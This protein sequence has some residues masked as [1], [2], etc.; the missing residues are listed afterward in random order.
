MAAGGPVSQDGDADGADAHVVLPPLTV[1][2]PKMRSPHTP[3]PK[4]KI[5]L[6]SADEWEEFTY[7]WV[8]ALEEGYVGIELGGGTGD[9]G[10]D[11]AAFLTQSKFNGDWHSYQCKHYSAPLPLATAMGEILKVFIAAWE[12]HYALPSRYVFVAPNISRGLQ[13][14]L[15]TPVELKKAFLKD[16]TKPT[17]KAF[18]ALESA[19]RQ[20]VEQLAEANDFSLFEA[21]NLDDI[22]DLHRTTRHYAT[23]FDEPFST[24]PEV[25]F[26]PEEHASHESR[27]IQQLLDVYAEHF[28]AGT[29]ND[30]TAHDKAGPHLKRQREAFYSAEA[31]RMFAR[32]HVP[33]GH[34]EA[35]QDDLYDSVV[36]VADRDFPNGW[37]RVQAVLEA[38]T[39]VQVTETHLIRVVRTRDR[40]GVCHQLANDDRLTWCTGETT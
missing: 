9:R 16:L 33:E 18:T 30:V 37:A 11:V 22:L 1:L 23:R 7:E 39:Q 38:S 34:F 10:V 36:E 3:T 8:R 27:Y 15:A 40:K 5:S 2:G 32:D 28:Q 13:R 29:L 12:G 14:M 6:Y 35:L 31:L 24:R 21:A 20:G 4:Q 25:R 19:V 17:N 26:P